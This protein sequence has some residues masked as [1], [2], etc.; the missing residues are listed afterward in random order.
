MNTT[1]SAGT[2]YAANVP[3]PDGTTTVGD[4]RLLKVDNR[5]TCQLCHDPTSGSA[6][7]KTPVTITSSSVANPTVITTAA[8]HGLVTGD[9]VAIAGHTGSTPAISGNFTVTVISATTFTIP[10][11]VTV[12]GSGGT[13]TKVV[14]LGQGLPP[15]YSP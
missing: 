13:A 15:V 9:Q 3:Y 2:T 1:A 10:V 7:A 5:G 11:N 8:A 6:V 14:T 4:S 12:A